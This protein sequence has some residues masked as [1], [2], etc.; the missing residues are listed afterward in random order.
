MSGVTTSNMSLAWYKTCGYTA[1]AW[2]RD[3]RLNVT[4]L[5]RNMTSSRSSDILDSYQEASATKSLTQT[6]EEML[7]W[8]RASLEGYDHTAAIFF[9]IPV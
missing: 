9:H 8:H 3:S 6:R 5:G 7:S 1:Q 2:D 4:P